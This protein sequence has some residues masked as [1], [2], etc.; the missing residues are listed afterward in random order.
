MIRATVMIAALLF[1][2]PAHAI[3]LRWSGGLAEYGDAAPG[4]VGTDK[5]HLWHGPRGS[6]SMPQEFLPVDTMVQAVPHW[7]AVLDFG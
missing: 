7:V 1:A 4:I 3:G 6:P 2:V 5:R